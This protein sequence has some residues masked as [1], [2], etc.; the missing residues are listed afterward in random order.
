MDQTKNKDCSGGGIQMNW[1]IQKCRIDENANL[2]VEITTYYQTNVY[3]SKI[4]KVNLKYINNCTAP[5]NLFAWGCYETYTLKTFGNNVYVKTIQDGITTSKQQK[6]ITFQIDQQFEWGE[7]SELYKRIK[8]AFIHLSELNINA[9]K[10][11][12]F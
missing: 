11:E 7:W 9:Q 5:E 2:I 10:K 3:S 12:I 8:K 4:Y 6:D 1:D